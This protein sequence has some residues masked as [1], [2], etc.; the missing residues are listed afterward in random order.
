MATTSAAPPAKKKP[1]LIKQTVPVNRGEITWG[2]LTTATLI[3]AAFHICLFALLMLIGSPGQANQPTETEIKDE[4]NV[5][6]EANKV[7]DP[8]PLSLTTDINPNP[9]EPNLD[10]AYKSQ[11]KEKVSVPGPDD[12]LKSA[13]IDNAPREN[14]PISLP[15]PPGLGRG[16]GGPVAM[17]P[18][19]GVN[20]PGLPG[21]YRMDAARLAG[22][23]FGRSGATKDFL[24]QEGGGT[25]ESEAAVARGLLWIVRQQAP[26]GHFPLD[27][28]FPNKGT[29]N[30]IA[31]TAFG[32]LPLLGAGYT[33]QKPRGHAFT[34]HIAMGLNYL[35]SKQDGATGGFGDPSLTD[36]R[37]GKRMINMYTHGLAS[38]AMCEAYGLTQDPRYGRSAELAIRFI[39]RA[40]HPE[41]GW[42]YRPREAGDLS[43]AGWQVM[44]L[45]S[46]Q[47]ANI[48][49]SERTMRLAQKFLDAMSTE[50]EGYQYIGGSGAT[51]S[52]S[53]VGL[54]CRQYIQAWGPT[55]PRLIRGIDSHLKTN[56]P[57]AL[58]DIYYYYY[59][60]QVMHHY[61]VREAWTE[62][63]TKM[64]DSLI[65]SQEK[66][67]IL[68]INGSWAPD[69]EDRW[70]RTGGRMMVTSMSLLTLEVYYRY[71]PLYYQAKN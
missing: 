18:K 40:Q 35:I 66:R 9:E 11:R 34:R 51:P 54:L 60:T 43:V 1:L 30:H 48:A 23:F 25:T 59:A 2:W 19:D 27:G 41:G 31:G 39:E 58:K 20:L 17:N 8:D 47:M 28:D 44:A 14:P 71:L 3:S 26:D 68:S 15:L 52:M 49:V 63:N 12:L 32:L 67:D 21:G 70:G 33:H 61:G 38:I 42:R 57:G 56:P 53:A 22:T 65:Q 37:T 46:A 16:Q 50:S 5:Q 69:E 13:G 10:I 7:K 45:K 55:N 4:T 24:L 36:P 62:W 64:R 29:K 6:A